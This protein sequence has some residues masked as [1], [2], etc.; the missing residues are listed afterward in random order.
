MFCHSRKEVVE[1]LTNLLQFNPF[2][3]LSAADC[4]Q[5]T[6]FDG[7]RNPLMER[8]APYKIYLQVDQIEYYEN[9]HS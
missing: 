2:F 4:L 8:P 1:I 3:R 6:I 9:K 7:I 5:H